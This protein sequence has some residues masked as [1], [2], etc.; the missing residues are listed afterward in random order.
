MKLICGSN[1]DSNPVANISWTNAKG[2]PITNSEKYT[3]NNGPEEVSLEI[4]GVN[5][6]D[7][8]TW[9]CTVHVVVPVN[10]SLYCYS[11]QERIKAIPLQLIVVSKL[12]GDIFCSAYMI[13]LHI[14]SSQ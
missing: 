7:N 14:S 5:K 10:V 9:T 6:D 4:A 2:E 3:I 13:C 1:L 11:E 8:G 12:K